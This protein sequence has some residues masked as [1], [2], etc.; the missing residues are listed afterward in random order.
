MTWEAEG[1]EGGSFHSRRLHV[2]DSNSGLTLGRGYDLAARKASEVQTHLVHAGMKTDIAAVIAGAVGKR[3]AT[4]SR[5][6]L[7]HDLLDFE[8][9]PG[10]QLKLFARVYA[11]LVADV[12]RISIAYSK[13][14]GFGEL[15]WAALDPRIVS[16]L[17]DL[18]YRGDYTERSRAFLQKHVANN[19]FSKFKAEIVKKSNWPMVPENR[20]L[21]R[22][23]YVEGALAIAS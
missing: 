15:K 21:L 16:V 18:R 9:G 14:Q 5:F 1:S 3:G 13:K 11:E 20:V 10:V 19:D 7:E 4:A 17:V 2:P 22:K 6:V 8:I 12:K 23:M